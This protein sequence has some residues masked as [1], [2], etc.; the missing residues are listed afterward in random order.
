M[1]KIKFALEMKDGVKV[2]T[3]EELQTH[4]DLEKALLYFFDGKLE[5]WLEDRYYDQEV[6]A[7]VALNRKDA[8]FQEQFCQI[9][10]VQCESSLE[11]N[12][13]AIAQEYQKREK[14]RQLTDNEDIL[15]HA[16]D[17]AFTQE[18]ME[19]LIHAGKTTVYL[20]GDQFTI[21]IM[22]T[23][24]TYI[25]IPGMSKATISGSCYDLV[26]ALAKGKVTIQDIILPSEYTFDLVINL[27]EGNEA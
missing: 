16:G 27:E 14:L 25:G 21:S 4:F 11:A 2:R 5:K 3:L 24:I 22:D 20:C 10:G 8:D 9:L 13:N 26:T 19:Q 17:V 12:V 6:Q 23:P 15:A 7:L 1:A 18:E